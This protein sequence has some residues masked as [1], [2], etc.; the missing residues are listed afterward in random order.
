MYALNLRVVRRI[1]LAL[2]AVGVLFAPTCFA[3][4][5]V[6]TNS[7]GLQGIPEG[8]PRT[9]GVSNDGNVVLFSYFLPNFNPG[10]AT[11]TY[12]IKILSNGNLLPVY[13]RPAGER[14]SF[15]IL[16]AHG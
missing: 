9:C 13:R 4:D 10:P 3:I 16:R 5:L 14:R 15:S 1:Q 12:Y 7:A 2:C 11:G 6:S 8:S